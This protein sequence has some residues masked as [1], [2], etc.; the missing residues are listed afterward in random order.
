MSVFRSAEGISEGE[1]KRE[2]ISKASSSKDRSFH[3]EAQLS[4]KEGISS[5]M[6]RPPSFARPFRTTSSKDS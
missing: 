6:N 5:G 2:K 3:L 4:G 1:M